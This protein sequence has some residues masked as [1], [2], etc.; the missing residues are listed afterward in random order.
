MRFFS[1]VCRIVGSLPG[2]GSLISNL[3]ILQDATDDV[4]CIDVRGT[5][6]EVVR[7][8][9]RN[10]HVGVYPPHIVRSGD[11]NGF[12]PHAWGCT[13]NEPPL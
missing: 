9:I 3:S 12:S 10:L 8:D 1:V 5:S 11:L 4:H 2:P 7:R 6:V 13:E